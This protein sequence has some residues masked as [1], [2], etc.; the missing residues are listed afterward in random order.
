MTKFLFVLEMRSALRRE[1]FAFLGHT[2]TCICLNIGY[3]GLMYMFRLK[4]V[5][6]FYWYVQF[7][8]PDSTQRAI[9]R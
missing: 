2:F 6:T 8:I 1:E 5:L 3:T 7:T 4:A 9:L